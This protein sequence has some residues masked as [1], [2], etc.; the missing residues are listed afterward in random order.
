MTRNVAQ[1]EEAIKRIDKNLVRIKNKVD[2]NHRDLKRDIEL[3]R[4]ESQQ[5]HRDLKVSMRWTAGF[6]LGIATFL[7]AIA[8]ALGWID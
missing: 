2:D 7:V 6:A 4:L 5:A 3:L 8:K 1:H